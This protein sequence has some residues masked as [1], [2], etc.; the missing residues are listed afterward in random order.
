MSLI[1]LAFAAALSGQEPDDVPRNCLDDD[2]TNRCDAEVQARVRALLGV[3]AAEDEAATG[4]EIYRAFFVNGYGH[5]M[6]VVSFERRPGEPPKVVVSGAEGRRITA[7]VLSSVWDRVVSEARFADRTLA[8]P[9]PSATPAL[10]GG[11]DSVIDER[12]CLHSWVV[13]VEMANSL[14]DDGGES[15]VRRRTEDACNSGL[16][17]SYAFSLAE[18]AVS[19]IP[20]CEAL[21]LIYNRN[22]V[23]LLDSC[24]A[25]E[26]DTLAAA[27]LMN[28]K[29]RP[30]IN[31]GDGDRLVDWEI[32]LDSNMAGR[33]DWAGQVIQETNVGDS[34]RQSIAEFLMDRSLKLPYLRI[35][36][37]TFTAQ[38]PSRAGITGQVSYVETDDQDRRV[39]AADYR[40][41]WSR[42]GAGDWSLVSWTVDPFRPLP[43]SE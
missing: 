4:A 29:H 32:W 7:P 43:P 6:P 27:S 30:P 16:S 38:S 34:E 19:A 5:D 13:T 31:H 8:A 36:Q 17:I 22:A 25:L 14:T 28:Q 37:A 15:P 40:Q 33:L 41:E 42:R 26:G 39:M 24:L 11:D 20:A 21:E 18:I 23:T 9:T 12:I 1:A 2:H 35:H 3:A 10:G